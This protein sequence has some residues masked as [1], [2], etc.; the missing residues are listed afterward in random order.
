MACQ[1]ARRAKAGVTTAFGGSGFWHGGI[2]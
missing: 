1:P 2:L